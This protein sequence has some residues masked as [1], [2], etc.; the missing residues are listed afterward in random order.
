MIED[1]H[2]QQY[3]MWILAEHAQNSDFSN[4]LKLQKRQLEKGVKG[5]TQEG[6]ENVNKLI[7]DALEKYKDSPTIGNFLKEEK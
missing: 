3:A 7:F 4:I 6:I 5:V 1:R 2:I